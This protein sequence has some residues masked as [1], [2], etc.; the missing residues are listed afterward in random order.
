MTAR[1]IGLGGFKRSGKDAAG[2]YLE[3][4]HDFVKMSMSDLQSRRE[5]GN[6]MSGARDDERE[7]AWGEF[8]DGPNYQPTD[9]YDVRSVWNAAW[10]AARKHPEPEITEQYEERRIT[11]HY[12]INR[13]QTRTG[14]A[15][16]DWLKRCAEEETMGRIQV[17]R[18][19]V[20]AVHIGPWVPVRA[21]G[22]GEGEQ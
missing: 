22:S 10:D 21:E 13:D 5:A 14:R 4:K 9:R 11:F 3:S 7:A 17:D 18:R 20:R 15:S 12:G 1:L 6:L 19:E 2:D 8:R 16:F